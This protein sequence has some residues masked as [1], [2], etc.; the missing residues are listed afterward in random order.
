MRRCVLWLA[1]VVLA[2]AAVTPV[3]ADGIVI[4]DHPTG[5]L[6]IVYHRVTVTLRDG[7]AKTRVDQAF[8]NDAPVPVEGTYVFPLSPGAIVD[9]FTLWVNGKPVA[10]EVL[11][12]DQAREI[13]LAYLRQSRDP[14][15]LE[16]VGRDAFRARVFPIAP[17]ETR[18]IELE[19]TELLIPDAGMFRYA[20]PLAIERFSAR[21][22]EEVRIEVDLAA[23]YPLGS[24]YSPSH[25]LTVA[26]TS[27]SAALGTYLEKNVLPKKDFVLYYAFSETPVGA[28]LITYKVGEEDGWFLLLIAPPPYG[29]APVIPKDL[30]LVLDRS[31]SMEGVKMDQAKDAARFILEH[32]GPDDRFGVIA[33]NEAVARLTEGLTLATPDR[34]ATA[35]QAVG[36]VSA[37]GWT[38]IHDALCTAMKWFTPGNRPQYVIFLTDGLP[39]R[40]PTDTATIV[41]DVTMANVTAARLFAFGVGY[42]VDTHLL[43]LLAQGNRGTTTYVKPDESLE[44]A[45]SAFYRKIAEPALTDLA[46]TVDGVVVSD[47]YPRQLPDLFYGGQITLVGRYTG[48]G[49]ATVTL[50]ARRGDKVETFVYPHGFP[51]HATEADFLP[52]LWASRKIGYLLD[53]IRL[54]GEADEIVDQIVELALRYGIATPYTSFLVAE[55]ERAQLPPPD[56]FRMLSGA[57]AV[58]AAQAA[59]SMAE[60]EV[61]KAPDR[62]REVGGRV[63]ILRDTTWTESTY[64]EGA[65]VVKVQYLSGAYWDL[66]EVLSDVG[67]ILALGEE[68]LFKAGT[69][70]VHVGAEG[71]T[72]LTPEILARLTG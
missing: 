36:T 72:E 34:V 52:R 67:P 38:N 29:D 31:G 49:S 63:F 6:T 71:L 26:R 28:D 42:D 13:Y 57:P 9:G 32:L 44:H 55:D 43:D 60:A 2:L 46:L 19:Y 59:K 21:P 33:F 20:Y 16:Y 17:D 37:D 65:P 66:L 47:R 64:P 62:V 48:S 39:T 4:P 25:S 3:L 69:V 53:R 70:F 8:R 51:S 22:I 7:V 68:V 41:R 23:S 12:A 18:R 30:V 24:V 14:A 56:A 45:L 35:V 40:G 61:V 1:A 10:G 27:P 54:E 58:G 5:W 15:L 11:P 50:R